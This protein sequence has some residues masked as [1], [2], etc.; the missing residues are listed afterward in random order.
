MEDTKPLG[1]I[2]LVYY[3]YRRG[4]KFDEIGAKIRTDPMRLLLAVSVLFPQTTVHATDQKWMNQVW[5]E[6]KSY[7]KKTVNAY[8][9]YQ[10]QVDKKYKVFYDA[11]HASLDQLEKTVLEDQKQW[12]EKLQADLDQLKLKYEG[13]VI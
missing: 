13:T 10:K 3:L 4:A 7:N 12:D 2:S 11:S 6:Y 9:N 1:K 8:N 5:S